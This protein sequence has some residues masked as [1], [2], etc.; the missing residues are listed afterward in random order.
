MLTQATGVVDWLLLLLLPGSLLLLLP[1][2]LLLLLPGS[3]LLLLGLVVLVAPAGAVAARQQ[4]Q[5]RR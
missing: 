1:G 5:E 2:S 4:N 3:P